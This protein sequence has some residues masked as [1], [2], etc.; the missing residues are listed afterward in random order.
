MSLGVALA[1]SLCAAGPVAAQA[2]RTWVSGVGD[3]VNPC[4]RTA[5]CKTFAGAISKTAKGG[6]IN[7]LDPGGF[8]TVTITKSI[9]IDGGGMLASIIA[10][11]TT[12]VIVNAPAGDRVTLRRLTINGTNDGTIDGL[13]GV[14]ALGGA[15][16]HVEDCVIENFNQVGISL[17]G[18]GNLTVADTVI[19]NLAGAGIRATP[20]GGT[21]R[22]TIERTRMAEVGFGVRLSGAV[23]ALATDTTVSEAGGAGFWAE[24]AAELHLDDVVVAHSGVGIQASDGA[25]VNV[26]HLT[27]IG[28]AG[29]AFLP[30]TGGMIVPFAGDLIT[31]NPPGGASTCEL[32]G[33]SS[34]VACLGAAGGGGAVCPTPV[35]PEPSCPAPVF[36]GPALGNCKRCKTKGTKTTCTGCGI[37]LE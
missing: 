13:Y 2:S 8:G 35:C 28:N 21:P 7:A 23:I 31:A 24:G 17:E 5:P 10:S 6:E 36:V 18:T 30:E 15:Q 29:G 3:D 1:I 33:A 22:I 4:S 16:L 27:A 25:V 34:T 20:G 11:G 37:D 9:V 26:A 12:G 19:R 32:A 14:R